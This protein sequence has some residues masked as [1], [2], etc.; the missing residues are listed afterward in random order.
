MPSHCLLEGDGVLDVESEFETR[1]LPDSPDWTADTFDCSIFLASLDTDVPSAKKAFL[2]T[3]AL[4]INPGWGVSTSGATIGEVEETDSLARMDTC[5][6]HENSDGRYHYHY[7]SPCI[8]D[9]TVSEALKNSDRTLA[10]TADDVLQQYRDVFK[11]KLPYRSVFGL[12][13][14]GRPIYTPYHGNLKTYSE[15]DVD[16]CNGLNIGGHYAYVTTFFYPWYTAC[17]GSGNV[18]PK[19]TFRCLADEYSRDGICNVST[20]EGATG[21][22]FVG[23]LSAVYA[24]L[25]LI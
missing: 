18:E 7:P 13:K 2:N 23:A 6:A 24:S 14:D 16:Y 1:W 10:N 21:L 3:G 22:K 4:K 11:T 19:D 15:C 17:Y 12:A 8:A 9:S 20:R 25:Y 5:I